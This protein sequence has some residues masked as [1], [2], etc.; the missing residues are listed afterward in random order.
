MNSVQETLSNNLKQIRKKKKISQQYI[1]ERSD[2]L[3][4][5]YNR[6]EN[7]KVT[8]SIET[9]ERIANAIEVPFVELFKSR[10]VKDKSLL[11][12]LEMINSLSDYNKN[13]VEILLN[14]IIEKDKLENA[15]EFKVQQRL[16]ELDKLKKR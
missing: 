8:P 7:M 5:T 14:T 1:A 3:A 9:I 13:V 11:D 16:E 6:I 2:M 12:K 15:K 4:S 10:H